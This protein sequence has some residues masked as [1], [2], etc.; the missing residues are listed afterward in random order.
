MND[1]IHSLIGI[2]NLVF[3]AFQLL[4][5]ASVILSWIPIDPYNPIVRFI[6]QMTEPLLGALRQAMPFLRAGMID[7]TPI[8]AIFLLELANVLIVRV[9]LAIG[10]RAY[11]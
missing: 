5:I 4:V 11:A 2:V 1:P 6:R 8:A 3:Q 7:F 9:L 10:E